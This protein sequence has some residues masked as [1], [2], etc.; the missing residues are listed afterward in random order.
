MW[1]VVT[2]YTDGNRITTTVGFGCR[3]PIIWGMTRRVEKNAV[4]VQ[5]VGMDVD[6]PLKGMPP[7]E[8]RVMRYM[9]PV[10][11]GSK[12]KEITPE[13]VAR[14]YQ[15]VWYV[16]ESVLFNKFEHPIFFEPVSVAKP[17]A[18]PYGAGSYMIHLRSPYQAH[19][20]MPIILHLLYGVVNKLNA[21]SL[22]QL[23]AID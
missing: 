16:V 2:D 18:S 11:A 17:S 14:V 19:M 15:K 22:E 1:G 21:L 7:A 12:V 20:L 5:V 3:R 8:V 9:R 10:A 6:D 4:G 23:T 13:L